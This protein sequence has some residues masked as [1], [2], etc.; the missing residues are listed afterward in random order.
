MPFPLTAALLDQP[1][2]RQ[3]NPL[4]TEGPDKLPIPVAVAIAL[5]RT[6]ALVAVAPAERGQQFRL[7]HR[8][9]ESANLKTNRRFQ[10]IEPSVTGIWNR[11]RRCF[12][13]FHGVSSFRRL[14]TAFLR[15][16]QPGAY[17]SFPILHQPCDTTGKN[18]IKWTRLSCRKFRNNEIR[19]QLHALAYNLGT[20]VRTLA[21]P[22]EVE[23]W[24]LT[25][26]REKLVKIGAKVVRHGR[27]V[28]FQLAEVAVPRML[29]AEILRLIAQLRPPPDP[30]PA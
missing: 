24:S 13:M 14:Q 8:L 7:H 28:T 22:K 30:A 26:L 29:F 19:L 9:D 6:L 5:G 20:F 16:S 3:R 1:G 21:L 2:A 11:R 25:T 17:A 18:A 10:R 15:V 12:K 27:Y 4:L 23:H